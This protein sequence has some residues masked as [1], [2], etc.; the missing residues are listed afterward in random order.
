MVFS[1]VLMFVAGSEIGHQLEIESE[2]MLKKILQFRWYQ[3]DKKNCQMLIMLLLQIQK[4][5]VIKCFGAPVINREL[6]LMRKTEYKQTCESKKREYYVRVA[7]DLRR[8]R[9]CKELW[10]VV[11]VFKIKNRPR[12]ASI[13]EIRYF[14]STFRVS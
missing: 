2:N 5:V 14:V 13:S 3:W 1:A 4:P 9:D 7:E 11:G 12:C 6:L 8:A 10:Y